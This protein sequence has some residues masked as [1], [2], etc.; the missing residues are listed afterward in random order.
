MMHQLLA[1][2]PLCPPRILPAFFTIL[3]HPSPQF[4]RVIPPMPPTQRPIGPW[5]SSIK[6]WA[7]RSSEI[8]NIYFKSVVMANGLTVTSFPSHSVL[9]PKFQKPNKVVFSIVPNTITWMLSTWTLRLATVSLLADIAM[10]SSLLT[11]PHDT[12]GL[13]ASRLSPQQTLYL[14]SVSSVLWLVHWY[15]AFTWT[16][17]SNCLV[18]RSAD[19]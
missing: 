7:V 4:D 10:L 12:I 11:A 18:W 13:L 3:A 8:I 5:R 9:M 6:P 2:S 1:F 14:H 15:I 19:I 16:V 17:I